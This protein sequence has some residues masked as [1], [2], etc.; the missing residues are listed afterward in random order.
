M[1]DVNEFEKELE[2]LSADTG[3]KVTIDGKK[4]KGRHRKIKE[5]IAA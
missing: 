2:K 4:V 1:L 5:E 3:V